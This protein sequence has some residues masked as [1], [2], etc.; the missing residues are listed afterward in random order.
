MPNLA[1]PDAFTAS[2]YVGP[3]QPAVGEG[4]ARRARHAPVG[5]PRRVSVVLPTVTVMT[6][7]PTR[8]PATPDGTPPGDSAGPKPPRRAALSP[9]RINDFKQCPLLFRFRSVDRLPERPSSAAARGTLVHAVLERL[10]DLPRAERTAPAARALVDPAWQSLRAEEPAVAAL[11]PDAASLDSWLDEAR[12][13]LDSYFRLEDPRHLEPADRELLCEV[14]LA[15]G[16]LLR[17]VVDRLD[18]APDGALRVVDYKTGRS[19][20]ERFEGAAWFQ[21]RFYA[22]VLWRLRGVVPRRLQLMYLGDGRVLTHDPDEDS[23][24]ATER[25]IDAVWAAI[26]RATRDG[27]FVPKPS[28]LCGWCVHQ[29]LC[30]SFG[31]TPP[32]WPDADGERLLAVAG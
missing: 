1:L 7:R 11:F 20:S 2:A 24:R 29:S 28:R 15:S 4:A 25:T 5:G 18:V 26:E 16:V 8:A 12:A 3:G 17:G 14:E 22:L 27:V 30:P 19:P 10:F 21:M 32:P 13:L 23:L 31:G 6:P 9:S